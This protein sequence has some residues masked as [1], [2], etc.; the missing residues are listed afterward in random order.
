MNELTNC[1]DCGVA[2]GMAHLDGCDTARCLVTGG[3]RLS[4]PGEG[5]DGEDG[6]FFFEDAAHVGQDCGQDIWSGD[7]PGR[8]DAARL[9]FW[10]RWV[11]R[12][13]GEPIEF[14]LGR[15]GTWQSCRETDEGARPDLNRLHPP[16]AYWS[17]KTL[18][19]EAP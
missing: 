6:S 14:S 17:E 5:Y 7:F 11:D 8:D 2:P 19:W 10:C 3:Q 15:G 16:Y 9:G 1:H 12:V 4:C 18:R 13:T